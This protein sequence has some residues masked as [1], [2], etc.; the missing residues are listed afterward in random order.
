VSA[1]AHPAPRDGQLRQWPIRAVVVALPHLIDDLHTPVITGLWTINAYIIASTVFLLP[2]GRWSDVIGRKSI[3]IAGSLRF[4]LG[5]VVVA[6]LPPERC[7]WSGAWS[8]ESARR[9]VSPP[10]RRS[11]WARSRHG[12]WDVRWGLTRLR[13]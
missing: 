5:T 13:R 10:P 12:S 8:R 9:S 11:W 2:A 1:A 4:A 7:S 3:F 6:W